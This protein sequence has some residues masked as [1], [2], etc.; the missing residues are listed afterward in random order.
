MAT[1]GA[2]TGVVALAWQIRTRREGTHNVLIRLGNAVTTI[3]SR[4]TTLYSVEVINRGSAGVQMLNWGFL[5]P[6]GRLLQVDD[7]HIVDLP[8][9]LGAGT[10]VTFYTKARALSDKFRPEEGSVMDW[11]LRGYARLGTGEMIYS[12]KGLPYP[13]DML[14]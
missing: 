9:M 6:S 2:V 1:V 11:D 8:C 4:M 5:M 3:D 13:N 12:D 7:F 10:S 14:A